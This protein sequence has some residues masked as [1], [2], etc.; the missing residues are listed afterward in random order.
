LQ[1]ERN[2]YLVEI[3]SKGETLNDEDKKNKSSN[4]YKNIITTMI[5][6]YYNYGAELEHVKDIG[7]SLKALTSGYE[8]ANRE[9]GPDHSLTINLQ[10]GIQKLIEKK[11]VILTMFRIN[12]S[13]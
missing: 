13:V 12:L 7:S 11:K 3:V 5:M 8:L 10:L 4:K 1:G 2:Q 6:A 9:L